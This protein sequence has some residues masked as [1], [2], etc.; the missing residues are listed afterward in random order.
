MKLKTRISLKLTP[1]FIQRPGENSGAVHVAVLHC[2]PPHPTGKKGVTVHKKS[3]HNP[4]AKNSH[5][6]KHSFRHETLIFK[7][8]FLNSSCTTSISAPRPPPGH[9]LQKR[10]PSGSKPIA[11][12]RLPARQGPDCSKASHPQSLQTG[13]PRFSVKPKNQKTKYT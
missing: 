8:L 6:V 1:H 5:I 12:F 3:S 9:L 7:P 13:L 10:F 2:V 11:R 4:I